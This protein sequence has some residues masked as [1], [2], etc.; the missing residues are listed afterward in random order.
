MKGDCGM[1]KLTLNEKEEELVILALNSL[2]SLELLTESDKDTV[3]TMLLA[4]RKQ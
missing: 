1:K 2:F 4:L 3:K